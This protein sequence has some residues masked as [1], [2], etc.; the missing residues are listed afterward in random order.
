MSKWDY[1]LLLSNSTFC[2]VPRGRRLG[3]FRFIETLQAGCVPVLLSNGW[4]LPFGEVIDWSAAI[5]DADERLLMQVPEILHSVPPAKIFAMRQQTQMFWDRYLSS[6]EKIV[7]TT[8]EIVHDRIR[9]H[10]ARD[11]LIW[12]SD[13][14]ALL[15]RSPDFADSISQFPFE[16]FR[17]DSSRYLSPNSSSSSSSSLTTREGHS[18]GLVKNFTAVIFTQLPNPT[19]PNA[20]IFRLIRNI[21]RSPFVAKILVLWSSKSTQGPPPLNKW[22]TLPRNILQIKVL[23]PGSSPNERFQMLPEVETN[24]ILSLNDDSILTTDEIDFAF[25]VWNMFPDRIVGYPARSHYWNVLKNQWSFSSKWTND[26]SMVLTSGAFYHRYYHYLYSETLSPVMLKTVEQSGICEDILMNFLVSHVTKRCPIKLSQRGQIKAVINNPVN[27][28]PFKFD[29][30]TPPQI[31]F[32]GDEPV[33]G[34]KKK[35]GLL[36]KEAPKTRSNICMEALAKAKPAAVMAAAKTDPSSSN[37]RT[38]TSI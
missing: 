6:V 1:D 15:V 25:H 23:P 4:Q 10:Q 22:P 9:S 38:Y 16:H 7:M 29:P 27:R 37:T 12:N 5:I 28:T 14:G 26:Y 35:R 24:A 31:R 8:L 2:M 18:D 21:S 20:P 33:D 34:E 30:R 3:S 32:N 36:T 11:G 13:P 17:L 19:F